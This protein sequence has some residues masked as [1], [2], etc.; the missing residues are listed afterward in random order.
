MILFIQVEALFPSKN[1]DL[2][3][4]TVVE[5][6]KLIFN[7]HGFKK[8]KRRNRI[9]TRNGRAKEENK[10]VFLEYLLL[11]IIES[12]SSESSH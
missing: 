1:Q 2:F 3:Q 11:R 7:D 12:Q 10:D 4:T 5:A 8:K 9:R 6:L